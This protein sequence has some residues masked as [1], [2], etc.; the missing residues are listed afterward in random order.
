[1]KKKRNKPYNPNS[2]FNP[3]RQKRKLDEIQHKLDIHQRHIEA[4]SRSHDIHITHLANFA[5]H[6]IKNAIQNMDSVLSTT[7]PNEFDENK[8]QSLA[9]SLDIVRMTMDNFAKLVPYSNIGAFTLDVLL[10]ATELLARA[11]TQRHDIE[12]VFSYPRQNKILIA[13]PF[14]AVLQMMNNL[15]INAI[16][17]LETVSQKKLLV[18]ATIDEQELTIRI[19]DSGLAINPLHSEKIFEYGYSTTGGSGIGLFH[20]KYLTTEFN[21]GISVNLEAEPP[22]NKTFIVTL[23]TTPQN[24]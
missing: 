10:I 3:A 12:M 5:R 19:K 18:E 11:D 14:Q 6:D 7:Q 9:T 2:K 16:K 20:A 17:A 21:G 15:V 22:Y 4:I 8:V 24:G 23:P 13:L 1:M